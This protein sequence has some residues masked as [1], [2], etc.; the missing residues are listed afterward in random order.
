MKTDHLTREC[1]QTLI[2]EY[3]RTRA[4]AIED[5]LVRSQLGLVW[6]LARQHRVRGVDLEDLVQEGA[7]GLLEAIR[8]F[9][10]RRGVR[11]STY[12]AWWIR[13]FQWRFLLRNHRLVRIGTTEAQRRI[14]FRIGGLR[15]RLE[16]GGVEATPERMAE[17]LEVDVEA[18]RE[19]E[20]R[21]HSREQSLNASPHDDGKER[22]ENLATGEP[23]ADEQLSAQATTEIVVRERDRFRDTL[24]GRRR[25]LF[26]ARWLE[27]E[28]PT[29]RELG[30][31]FGISRER[32][33]QLEQQML[34]QLRA[35]LEDR[36]S[37]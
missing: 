8:R 18:V 22:I 12:A 35:R 28:P 23:A 17:I 16:A 32:A 29:L 6:R 14:F 9:E 2:E 37:A 30:D 27:P 24:D 19:M 11:L 7:L 15:A 26:D 4:P 1:E 31:R 21:L 36:L 3:G 5:Q 34:V 20:S 33:R 13:A 10:P 25:V